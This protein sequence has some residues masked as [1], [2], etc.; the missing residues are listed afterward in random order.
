MVMTKFSSR[1]SKKPGARWRFENENHVND[2]H[3]FCRRTSNRHIA[4]GHIDLQLACQ[5]PAVDSTFQSRSA[6]PTTRTGLAFVGAEVTRLKYHKGSQPQK[7]IR[8]ARIFYRGYCQLDFYCLGT[9]GPLRR[10]DSAAR[11]MPSKR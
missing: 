11:A 2:Y 10:C 1:M 4:A 9:D 6:V 8:G 5:Q 3:I 7:G